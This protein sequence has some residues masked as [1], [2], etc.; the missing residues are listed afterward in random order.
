[1]HHCVFVNGYYKKPDCLILSAQVDGAHTETIE[2]DLRNFSIVQS[3]G[4]CNQPSAYHTEI[5]N[6]M[7]ENMNK[8]KTLMKRKEVA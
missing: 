4:V 3:R 2:V 5:V 7:R 1:M 6:L 8:I